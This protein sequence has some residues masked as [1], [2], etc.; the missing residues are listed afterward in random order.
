MRLEV[1]CVDRH[2]FHRRAHGGQFGEDAVEDPCLAPSDEPVAERLVRAVAFQRIAPHQAAPDDM[3]DPA[4]DA[5]II[6]TRNAARLVRQQRAQCGRT[7]RR[8]ARS[9]AMT[10][11]TLKRGEFEA[12]L[13]PNGNP[14][15]GA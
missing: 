6:D 10:S 13:T 15:Y 11:K 1:V 7:A 9:G 3:N 5:A 12:Y 2:C 8:I 4:D 14:F